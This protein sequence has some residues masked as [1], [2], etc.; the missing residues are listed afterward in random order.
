MCF[1]TLKNEQ[2]NSSGKFYIAIATIFTSNSADF[3]V[4]EEGAKEYFL[5]QGA[6]YL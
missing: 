1:I 4:Y 6:G 2:N 5:P 3:V